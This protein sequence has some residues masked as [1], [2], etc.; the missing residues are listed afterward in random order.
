M[1]ALIT[2]RWMGLFLGQGP[3][4]RISSCIDGSASGAFLSQSAGRARSSCQAAGS[5]ATQLSALQS[6]RTPLMRHSMRAPLDFPVQLFAPAVITSG[7]AE[8]HGGLGSPSGSC[9]SAERLS[10]SANSYTSTWTPIFAVSSGSHE[11]SPSPQ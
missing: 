6:H 2:T 7:P 9:P 4:E 3:R 10:L 5:A 1:A 11:R 8:T